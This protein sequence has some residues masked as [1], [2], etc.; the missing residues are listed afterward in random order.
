MMTN[1]LVQPSVGEPKQFAFDG[2]AAENR[3]AKVKDR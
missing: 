3:T 2:L 1:I